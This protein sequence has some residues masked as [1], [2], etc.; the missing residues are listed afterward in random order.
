M[1]IEDYLIE[2]DYDK[3][4]L[5]LK[6]IAE[7]EGLSIHKV[8]AR[9]VNL[10]IYKNKPKQT[11]RILKAEY[12]GMIIDKLDNTTDADFE[13]LERLTVSLLK[14]LLDKL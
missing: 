13:Y 4:Q 2:E 12:V 5:A 11:K 3:Q 6:N 14:K 10:G 1:D 8:R 9:L 7:R